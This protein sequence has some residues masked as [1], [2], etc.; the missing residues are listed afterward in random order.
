MAEEILN[1]VKALRAFE[2]PGAARDGLGHHHPALDLF[3]LFHPS[4]D[5]RGWR[6]AGSSGQTETSAAVGALGELQGWDAGIPPPLPL[7]G[8]SSLSW[9]GFA[10]GGGCWDAGRGLCDPFFCRVGTERGWGWELNKGLLFP[11]HSQHKNKVQTNNRRL[12]PVL[13]CWNS[14]APG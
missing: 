7:L 13:F 1:F 11:G 3:L 14:L 6:G 4:R 2:L 8:N 10:P 9:V 5:K 12:F